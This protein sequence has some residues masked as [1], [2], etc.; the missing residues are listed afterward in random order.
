MLLSYGTFDPHSAFMWNARW[1]IGDDSCE[2]NI[3]MAEMGAFDSKHTTA[4]LLGVLVVVSLYELPSTH[5]NLS[6]FNIYVSIFNFKFDVHLLY[7]PG[8]IF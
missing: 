3:Y 5:V 6:N 4:F 1:C 7:G 8:L 2:H